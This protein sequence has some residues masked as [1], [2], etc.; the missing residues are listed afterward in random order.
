M[1]D[2]FARLFAAELDLGARELRRDVIETAMR[3]ESDTLPPSEEPETVDAGS[4]V[5][6]RWRGRSS[7]ISEYR[8]CGDA[9]TERS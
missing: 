2:T 3:E 6:R 8:D 4:P 9:E 1:I 5:R 7:H